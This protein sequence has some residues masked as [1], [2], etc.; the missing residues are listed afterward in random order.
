MSMI[1]LAVLERTS[2]SKVAA[3]GNRSDE[4]QR[5]KPRQQ[6]A[7]QK[8]LIARLGDKLVIYL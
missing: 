6:L 1:Y 8:Q 5:H 2:E 7:L 3:C 4:K